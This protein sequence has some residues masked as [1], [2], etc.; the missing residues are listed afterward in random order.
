MSFKARVQEIV[1]LIPAGKVATYGQIAAL[2]GHPGAARGCGQALHGDD[3]LPWHRVL[4]SQG[5]ISKGGSDYR[6]SVQRS[7][8]EAEG[9]A[10]SASGRCDLEIFGWDGPGEDG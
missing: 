5:R 4:N 3:E 10:F 8:L 2:A 6:P 7:M 9:V 1:H